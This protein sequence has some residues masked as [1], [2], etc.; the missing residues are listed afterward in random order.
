MLQISKQS[1]AQWL[2]LGYMAEQ[3]Y[4]SERVALFTRKYDCSLLDFEAKIQSAET[5]SFEEWD[6]YIEW[7]AYFDFLVSINQK[8]KEVR[9]GDFQ[10]VG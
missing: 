1:I 2:L 9:N 6:D 10:M 8:I 7:K 5:E 3:K 4:L